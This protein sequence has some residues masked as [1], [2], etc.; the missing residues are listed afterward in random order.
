[1]L[2][3]VIKRDQNCR[4]GVEGGGGAAARKKTKTIVTAVAAAAA[5]GFVLFFLVLLALL[6]WT[7]WD[8]ILQNLIIFFFSEGLER[9][10]K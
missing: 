10:I 2:Q 5:I 4:G 7:F 1:M 3:Q 9:E 6:A 8:R